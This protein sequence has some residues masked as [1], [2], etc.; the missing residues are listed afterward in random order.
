MEKNQPSQEE[1]L[2]AALAHGSILLFGMG[3][4]AAVVLWVTQKERSRYVAF[5]ALQAVAYHIA[6][7][8]IFMASMACWLALYFV[9]LI[10]LIATPEESGGE[11]LWFF[12]LATILMLAPFAQMG[13]WIVGGW[14]GAAR[15]LQGREFRYILIGRYLEGWLTNSRPLRHTTNAVPAERQG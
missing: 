12:L 9:S 8:A 2:T 6:G 4:V 10:P 5:Q 7:F 1:R 14:W 15:A 11:A 13:L 3:I